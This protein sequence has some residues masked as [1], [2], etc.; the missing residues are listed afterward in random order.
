MNIRLL[1]SRLWASLHPRFCLRPA[2]LAFAAVLAWLCLRFALG[3]PPGA[4]PWAG[5]DQ[6]GT[7]APSELVVDHNG[8]Y[9][10]TFVY[11][12]S[13]DPFTTKGTAYGITFDHP[14][15]RQQRIMTAFLAHFV[16]QLPA[17]SPALAII[18]VNGL[19][20]VIAVVAGI[21]LAE[22]I[23]RGPGVGLLLALPACLPVSLAADLTEPVAWA[24]LLCG[25]LAARGSRWMRAS[26][27]FSVAVLA[28]E[29]AAVVIAGYVVES[30]WRL[31]KHRVAA[32]R[33]RLWLALP[34]VFE[35]AW[36]LRLWAVWGKLPLSQGLRS[37]VLTSGPT[38]AAVPKVEGESH[39]A[40]L[41]G[42]IR[43]FLNGFVRGDVSHPFLGFTYLVERCVLVALIG[44]AGWLLATRRVRVGLALTWAWC[45]AALVALSMSGWIDDIQFLRPTMEVWGLSIFVLGQARLVW[46]RRV[47]IAA[48]S[49]VVWGAT[50]ALIRS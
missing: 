38:R 10:G 13:L 7:G 28:R 21:A 47:L 6:V 39:S 41:L 20:V 5:D 19:A 25:I 4:F 8:G 33:G 45:L 36:Q 44:V 43:T 30:L 18:I 11:R 42:I 14:G 48:A 31:R 49:V 1:E 12:L 2:V 24:G 46:P 27:A 15:Y 17:I 35:S 3:Y 32:E 26:V 37:T 29:T 16:S 50:F 23:G 9:D 22:Q 34:V 40:P